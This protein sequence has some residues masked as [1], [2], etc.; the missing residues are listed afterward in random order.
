MRWRHLRPGELDHERIWFAVSVA[1]F[2]LAWM[3]FATDLRLPKCLWHE[4]TGLPCP[5][6]GGTRCARS[7]IQG[8]W[9][10]AI[11]MNPLVFLGLHA[12]VL[13]NLYAAV[14]LAFRLPRLRF[15][16]LPSW[17]GFSARVGVVLLFALNWTW[18]IVS[19][20]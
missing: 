16:Q 14:I 6:C 20:R 7:L 13:Y 17:A 15:D 11:T 9:T 8:D 12:V 5:S 1:A 4:F 3:I 10:T 18:L 2:L 19:R